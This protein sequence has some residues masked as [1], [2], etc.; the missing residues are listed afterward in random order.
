MP[1]KRIPM[2]ARLIWARLAGGIWA[3]PGTDW[4]N[5]NGQLFL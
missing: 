1:I 2:C 5:S 4:L 3:A